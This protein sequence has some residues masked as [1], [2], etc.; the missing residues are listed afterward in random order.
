[1]NMDKMTVSRARD[2]FAWASGQHTESIFTLLCNIGI[3]CNFTSISADERLILD[4]MDAGPL[5]DQWQQRMEQ[6]TP[7]DAAAFIRVFLQQLDDN[8]QLTRPPM[9]GKTEKK[10]P[11]EIWSGVSS[12]VVSHRTSNTDY[13]ELHLCTEGETVYGTGTHQHL[14]KPGNVVLIPPGIDCSYLMNPNSGTSLHYWCQ[15]DAQTHWQPWCSLLHEQQDLTILQ[16]DSRDTGHLAALLQS[17]IDYAYPDDPD[18]FERAV[19]N[20][21]EALLVELCALR[22]IPPPPLDSR[23]QSALSYIQQHFREDWGIVDLASHCHLSPGR[24][25][26]LFKQGLG[27]SPMSLRDS[28][29]MGE[30]C[31]LLLNSRKSIGR[32]GEELGYTDPMHFSRRFSELIGQNPRQYRSNGYRGH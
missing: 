28:L 25:S 1:M 22:P 14:V 23:V 2:F 18:W 12:G 15:F 7:E 5:R 17:D 27:S 26:V 13:W 6:P 16:L 30:A 3:N 8:V 21:I 20:R 9:I 10:N 32:I 19:Y 31:H 29:R 4:A 24:L 11:G